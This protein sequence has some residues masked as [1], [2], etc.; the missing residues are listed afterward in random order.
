MVVSTG[1]KVVEGYK[2]PYVSGYILVIDYSN[3]VLLDVNISS[4]YDNQ[5]T[6][7]IKELLSSIDTRT[8]YIT[9]TPLP[10]DYNSIIS[11]TLIPKY[12]YSE[13]IVNL[14]NK[15]LSS[16]TKR[17]YI[18]ASSYTR[19]KVAVV[20]LS[21]I[22]NAT[23]SPIY[24]VR[25]KRIHTL[26]E[27]L[28][29]LGSI[30]RWSHTKNIEVSGTKL[31]Y[32]ISES[33]SD[34]QPLP[35]LFLYTSMSGINI[36]KI[37]Y[38]DYLLNRIPDNGNVVLTY[39]ELIPELSTGTPVYLGFEINDNQSVFLE[40]IPTA[41]YPLNYTY[42]VETLKDL[43]VNVSTFIYMDDGQGY[44]II[45]NNNFKY[46]GDFIL[47]YL[48]HNGY[49]ILLSSNEFYDVN[50]VPNTSRVSFIPIES[51]IANLTNN[52]SVSV[53]FVTHTGNVSVVIKFGLVPIEEY[54]NILFIVTRYDSYLFAFELW[55]Q[56]FSV[57]P[58]TDVVANWLK[59]VKSATVFDENWNVVKTYG[60]G[61]FA[62]KEK[63]HNVLVDFHRNPT[64]TYM[65]IE[66]RV[67][68]NRWLRIYLY[69]LVEKRPFYSPEYIY[70]VR[71]EFVNILWELQN[72]WQ[73]TSYWYGNWF[74]ID[75]F[76][77][78]FAGV[79]NNTVW[80]VTFE[81]WEDAVSLKLKEPLVSSGIVNGTPV[82]LYF[83]RF[84]DIVRNGKVYIYGYNRNDSVIDERYSHMYIFA[85]KFESNLQTDVSLIDNKIYISHS[86]LAVIPVRSNVNT[87]LT[88]KEVE[89][90]VNGMNV[91]HSI[92]LPVANKTLSK[93]EYL[94]LYVNGFELLKITKPEISLDA[95]FNIRIVNPA[96][97]TVRILA[98][99][100]NNKQYLLEVSAEVQLIYIA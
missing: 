94:L 42:L 38:Q 83:L 18:Y 76:L 16:E 72:N 39:E 79:E 13:T 61:Q 46:L 19:D 92:V 52:Q 51:V 70:E 17:A 43:P 81:N 62:T 97:I 20:Y 63:I 58:Y 88:V 47:E 55:T 45:G 53:A 86:G 41:K 36:Y 85:E 93:D 29:S 78:W 8:I 15:F 7:Y 11:Q 25:I 24:K 74:T 1:F 69:D 98:V 87:T 84:D 56:V 99:D 12:N 30:I 60:K 66:Y 14:L 91:T 2:N 80:S 27:T 10:N 6:T 9:Q 32:T 50:F 65:I 3:R 21:L 64:Y 48:K 77:D 26:S 44:R 90:L 4:L 40:V 68:L 82:S 23:H 75:D 37:S 67:R 34:Y 28:E 5:N 95:L 33:L 57:N 71:Y 96:E 73:V 59:Y 49:G 35:N 89:I 100:G 22:E 54:E 31:R